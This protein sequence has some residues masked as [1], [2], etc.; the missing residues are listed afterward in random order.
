[1][2]LRLL[3]RIG[4]FQPMTILKMICWLSYID[5]QGFSSAIFLHQFC[6]IISN[7]HVTFQIHLPKNLLWKIYSCL[8][9]KRLSLWEVF[10]L[11]NAFPKNPPGGRFSY[12]W[13]WT[14]PT[15]NDPCLGT[16]G[17]GANETNQRTA[18]GTGRCNQGGN[19]RRPWSSSDLFVRKQLGSRVVAWWKG[20]R[21]T[22]NVSS[23]VM[24]N[25]VLRR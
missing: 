9:T 17:V 7:I 6:H 23:L 10:F 24:F 19:G 16:L 5:M 8:V 14:S 1:M 20:Q 21:M 11:K 13:C 2:L 4:A 25:Y 15:P 3:Q 22:S 12:I 18:G